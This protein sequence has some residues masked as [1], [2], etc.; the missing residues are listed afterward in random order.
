MFMKKNFHAFLFVSILLLHLMS[1]SIHA[2]SHQHDNEDNVDDHETCVLCEDAFISED[3]DFF[4]VSN[5]YELLFFKDNFP[6][7]IDQYESIIATK[8]TDSFHFGRP[9]PQFIP[10]RSI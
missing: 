4:I 5:S 10:Y 6:H 1:A 9:P 2:F 8:P 3:L 7:L